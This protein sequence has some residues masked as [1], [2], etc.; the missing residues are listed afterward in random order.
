MR[1]YGAGVDELTDI[2]GKNLG[3]KQY[4]VN[5][6]CPNGSLFDFIGESESPNM[7]IIKAMFM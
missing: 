3:E 5:E 4:I 7:S 2:E 1:I 6:Y